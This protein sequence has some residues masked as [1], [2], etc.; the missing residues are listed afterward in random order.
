MGEGKGTKNNQFER[1]EAEP[2][3]GD[4]TG[5]TRTS[6]KTGIPASTRTKRASIPKQGTK[7]RAKQSGENNSNRSSGW[8]KRQIVLFGSPLKH[9]EKMGRKI[10]GTKTTDSTSITGD[11][12]SS[13]GNTPSPSPRRKLERS[14]IAIYKPEQFQGKKLIKSL[15]LLNF[16][17]CAT[18]SIL[19]M[20]FSF[21]GKC[22]GS[23]LST[24]YLKI[25]RLNLIF[26]VHLFS[27]K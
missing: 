17:Y 8:K 22:G 20:K 10:R 12:P 19:R 13:S 23:E 6:D 9:C 14:K 4:N 15:K 7:K 3:H 24:K 1:V 25:K 18:N 2:K 11:T 16:L 26:N 21:R 27:V 5:A